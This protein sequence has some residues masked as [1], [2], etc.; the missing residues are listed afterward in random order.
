MGNSKVSFKLLIKVVYFLI[1]C[2]GISLNAQDIGITDIVINEGAID[3]SAASKTYNLCSTETVTLNIV[4][5][6]FAATTENIGNYNVFL[7]INGVNTLTGGA[8][9][10]LVSITAA[11]IPLAA[12]ATHTLTYPNDFSGSPPAFNF[13]NVGISTIVVSATTTSGT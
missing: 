7:R 2:G 5:K 13:S 1:L 12:G 6:N 4:I 3:S 10:T 11:S 9:S 8:T